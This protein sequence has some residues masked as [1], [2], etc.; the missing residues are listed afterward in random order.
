MAVWI[1]AA[2]VVLFYIVSRHTI[3]GRY[4]YAVGGSER[5]AAFSGLNVDRIKMRVYVL[6][7]GLAAVAGFLVYY[8]VLHQFPQDC[9]AGSKVLPG[10]GCQVSAG[11]VSS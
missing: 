4:I 7:G 8:G 6:G 5:A 10:I 9:P 1:S 3:L 11:S 2:L